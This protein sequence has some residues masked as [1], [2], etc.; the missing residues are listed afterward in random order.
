MAA[1]TCPLWIVVRVPSFM[2]V[3]SVGGMEPWFA[4]GFQMWD[5]MPFPITD[6]SLHSSLDKMNC[7]CYTLGTRVHF[8]LLFRG[9]FPRMYLQKVM[10]FVFV[11]VFL[12][13]MVMGEEL[14]EW[15]YYPLPNLCSPCFTYCFLFLHDPHQLTS[16]LPSKLLDSF[17]CCC[18]LL[19]TEPP[20]QNLSWTN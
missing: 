15:C 11:F 19:F 5:S 4:P 20:M 1:G 13:V 18:F 3:V 12:V 10:F 14:S 6:G 17:M 2:G 9:H 16:H 8:V 7:G